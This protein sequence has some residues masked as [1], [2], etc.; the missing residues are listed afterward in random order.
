MSGLSVFTR[1]IA[2]LI[3]ENAALKAELEGSKWVSVSERLPEKDCWVLGSFG[4]AIEICEYVAK[5][6]AFF[7][8]DDNRTGALFPTR[9]MPLPEPPTEP[10]EVTP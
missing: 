9:W 1:H 7:S 10:R 8:C 3:A 6:K 2:A 4:R 5:F